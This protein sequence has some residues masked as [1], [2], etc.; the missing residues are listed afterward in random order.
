MSDYARELGE[1]LKVAREAAGLT[2]QRAAA[3]A[4]VD[5]GTLSK[6]ELGKVAEPSMAK[7]RRLA[8]LYGVR[9]EWLDSGD[10]PMKHGQERVERDDE[11]GYPEIEAYIEAH[12]ELEPDE[13]A[14]ARRLRRSG[15][16]DEITY[17][18]VD[19][20]VRGWRA[21]KRGRAIQRPKLTE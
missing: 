3:D 1:R 4:E 18:V 14:A 8:L 21:R 12:P 9:V 16:P 15:G 2:Q 19:G 13:I 7:V 6:Y 10:G 11:L 20:F 17:E 5:I